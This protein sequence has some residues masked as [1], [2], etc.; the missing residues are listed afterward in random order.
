MGFF[1]YRTLLNLQLLL[2]VTLQLLYKRTHDELLRYDTFL[3]TEYYHCSHIIYHNIT[4]VGGIFLHY[5]YV[6]FYFLTPRVHFADNN[7]ILRFS[8]SF[9]MANAC[10]SL[11]SDCVI[12]PFTQVPECVF[13]HSPFSCL[14]AQRVHPTIGE[15]GLHLPHGRHHQTGRGSD[16]QRPAGPLQRAPTPPACFPQRG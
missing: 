11:S 6:S 14:G 10:N 1:L 4:L 13:H 5:L 3:Y 7:C 12:A 16:G 15:G 9:K 8:V 2:S